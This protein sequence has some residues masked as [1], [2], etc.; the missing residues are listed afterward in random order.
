MTVTDATATRV[1]AIVPEGLAPGWYDVRVSNAGPGAPSDTLTDA[2]TITNALDHFTFGPVL[3]QTAGVSF[4]VMITAEDAFGWRV[5]DYTGS[6]ALS[7]STGTL[8]PTMTSSFTAG[9]V[10]ATLT[11]TRAQQ[12]VVI[13]AQDGAQTGTSQAF[14][15]LHAP[16]D[17]FAFDPLGE[18]TAGVP[19]TV[20]ITAV[21]AFGNPIPDYTGPNVLV[22]STGTLSPTL[23]PTFTD[24][25]VQVTATI[26]DAQGGVVI[27][28]WNQAS[29]AL[30]PMGESDAFDVV[31]G[32]LDAILIAPRPILT[33][34]VGQSFAIT[35]TV[36]DAY[37]NVLS[38]FN[39]TVALSDTTGTITPTEVVCNNGI[40][41]GAVT[42]IQDHPEVY[43]IALESGV[44]RG[45]SNAFA[46]LGG[47]LATFVFSQVPTQT[48]GVPFTVTITAMDAFANP[49]TA[50]SGFN[51]LTDTTGTITPTTT[52]AFVN[53]TVQLAVTVNQAYAQDVITT[54]GTGQTGTSNAFAVVKST[55]DIYLPLVS[56]N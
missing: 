25:I 14:D 35:L 11:I 44:A 36:M 56:R 33:Q 15:V 28:T 37:G 50:Y 22:D 13:T 34:T 47:P 40:W 26:T 20:T 51:I 54:T 43:I 2:L 1:D 27:N 17:H 8:S 3:T 18:Q 19:F 48:V 31:A 24:G 4:T 53:G 52:P 38:D 32:P 9:T 16:L 23:T 46:V 6:A 10:M 41:A 55:W 42:I 12:D 7:D 30:P 39:G 49:V 29:G 45:R 5:M 21:D